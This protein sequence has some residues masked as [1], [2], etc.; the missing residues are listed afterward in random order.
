M[1]HWRPPNWDKKYISEIR[2]YL[3]TL[4]MSPPTE[5]ELSLVELGADAILKALREQ[6]RAFDVD[7]TNEPLPNIHTLI[8]R[9]ANARP[10]QIDFHPPLNGII[11]VIPNDKEE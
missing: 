1:T 2:V 4:A 9:N 6:Q 3:K 10:H 5:W 7:S 11:I 8:L